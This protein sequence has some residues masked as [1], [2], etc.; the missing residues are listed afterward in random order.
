MTS[1]HLAEA[2]PSEERLLLLANGTYDVGS[3]D[4]NH[5]F[6]NFSTGATLVTIRS[7]PGSGPV[8]LDAHG[9]GGVFAVPPNTTLHLVGL[10]IIGGNTS[11]DGGAVHLLGGELRA[12]ECVFENNTAA[13]RGGRSTLP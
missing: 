6:W 1:T 5:R 7:I 13:G 8:I 9:S 4:W 10:T 12:T 11:G 3:A 2:D